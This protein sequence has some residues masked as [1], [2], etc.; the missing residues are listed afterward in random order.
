MCCVYTSF[1]LIMYV[2]QT[3]NCSYYFQVLLLFS[4][5]P[6]QFGNTSVVTAK[7]L[8]KDYYTLSNLLQNLDLKP[9]HVAGPDVT[10][11]GDDF[12]VG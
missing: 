10:E 8:A 9:K 5:E 3:H 11:G 6:N 4:I 2:T 12:L 7:Q 1:P